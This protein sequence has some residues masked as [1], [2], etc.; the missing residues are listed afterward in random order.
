M[1]YEV[2]IRALSKLEKGGS[3]RLTAL[4]TERNTENITKTLEIRFDLV[5]TL[6]RTVV[7]KYTHDKKLVK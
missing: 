2:S 3:Q 7:L 4:F 5:I 1:H 6:V